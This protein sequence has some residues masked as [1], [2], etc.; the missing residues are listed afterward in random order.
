[1]DDGCDILVRKWAPESGKSTA[2]LHICHGVAE[3]SARYAGLAQRF[4][5]EGITV[6]AP[7]NRAHGQTALRS[8]QKGDKGHRLGHLE[9]KKGKNALE[10]IV[11]DHTFICGREVEEH[12][13]PLILLGH[14]LGSVIATLLAA[15]LT[16]HPPAALILSAAPARLPA[17]MKLAFGPLLQILGMLHGVAGVSPLIST[18]TFDKWNKEFSPNATDH[19]WL[20]RD[21]VEV[22]KYLNDPLCGFDVSVGFWKGIFNGVQTAGRKETLMKLPRCPVLSIQGGRDPCTMNDVGSNSAQQLASEFRDAGREIHKRITY[23]DGRHEILLETCR[24][25]VIQDLIDFV[26]RHVL[27]SPMRSKL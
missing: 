3:H 19:D 16:A 8:E 13:L 27:P 21:P 14:S 12:G 6:Y 4:V 1:M 23:G 17:A 20:N 22:Q 5:A 24:D 11:E 18:L 9:V 25:E 10:R 2:V 26:Q 15:N 7:D